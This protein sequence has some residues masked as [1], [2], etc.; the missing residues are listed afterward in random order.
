MKRLQHMMRF[1][2]TTRDAG[3]LYGK[4]RDESMPDGPLIIYTDS[5]WAGDVDT[6]ETRGGFVATAWQAPISWSSFKIKAVAASS[7]ESEYMAAFHAVRESKWLRALFS[8]L[9]HGDLSPTH[10]GKL[11]GKDYAR[12]KLPDL[13][14]REVPVM[15]LCDNK[16]AVAISGNSVLHNRSKHID[17]KYHFVRL[18]VNK[19]HVRFKYVNTKDN[20]ADLLTKSLPK[21]THEFLSGKLLH[22]MSDNVFNDYRGQAIQDLQLVSPYNM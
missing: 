5:D 1:L 10:F 2:C 22:S 19:R 6:R 17:I 16:G 20:L 13:D 11:C 18:E 8:D 3:I 14:K 4:A 21:V 7:C 15:C 12:E 9:G